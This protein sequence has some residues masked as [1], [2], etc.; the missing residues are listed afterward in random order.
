MDFQFVL[1]KI[2]RV[3]G[4]IRT[5]HQDALSNGLSS[6]EA[7]KEFKQAENS[8]HKLENLIHKHKV[9]GFD[10]RKHSYTK[11]KMIHTSDKINMSTVAETV[12]AAKN[13]LDRVVGDLTKDKFKLVN[14]SNNQFETMEYKTQKALTDAV[15]ELED[16]TDLFVVETNI[17]G[18]EE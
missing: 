11:P 8:I 18:E 2:T 10:S 1:S 5:A 7:D 17:P 3:K 16:L 6:K 4:L 15:D 13:L 14:K 12:N 9:V